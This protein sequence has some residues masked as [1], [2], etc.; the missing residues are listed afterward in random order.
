MADK[1]LRKMNRTELIEIIYALQQNEKTLRMENEELHRQLE[2]RL[3]RIENAGSIAEAAINLNHIFE[4]AE[5]AARQY[6][7]SVRYREREA[8][9]KLDE[10]GKQAEELL[11]SACSEK[12]AAAE[13][14]TSARS[15]K[16][17]AAEQTQRT[18]EECRIRREQTEAECT[19]LREQTKAECTALRE[20]T[21]AECSARREQ[22]EAECTAQRE[23]TTQDVK[24]MRAAFVREAKKILKENP[25]LAAHMFGKADTESEQ[26]PAGEN[27][28]DM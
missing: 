16:E 26:S 2:D 9:Q 17:A 23:Q 14:L 5:A 3:L 28:P 13:L 4:D 1:E 6:L 7:D 8:E 15:E 18:E 19:A 22:T 25:D 12:E 11:A 27:R 21:E 10:A 20:Q 24:R